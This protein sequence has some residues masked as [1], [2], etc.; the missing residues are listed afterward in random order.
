MRNSELQSLHQVAAAGLNVSRVAVRCGSWALNRS[1]RSLGARAVA[2]TG[3]GGELVWEAL[4]AGA[5]SAARS[6]RAQA[7]RARP[8]PESDVTRVKGSG[9]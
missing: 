9:G 6:S 3:L 2:R 1:L 7:A 8:A 5:R 4:S